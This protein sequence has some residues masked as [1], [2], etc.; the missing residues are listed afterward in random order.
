MRDIFQDYLVYLACCWRKL[1]YS[2]FTSN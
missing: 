1:Y 2:K